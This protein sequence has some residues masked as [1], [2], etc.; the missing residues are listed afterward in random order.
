MGAPAW[1]SAAPPPRL[2]D[3]RLFGGL[4]V[5]ETAQVL[6]VSADTVMR[7]WALA[8]AWLLRELAGDTPAAP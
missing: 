7:D 6:G 3:S 2:Q 1:P 8:K 5:N 4:T